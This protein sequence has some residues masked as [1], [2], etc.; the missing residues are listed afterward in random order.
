NFD[1]SEAKEVSL[2]Y[3]SKGQEVAISLENSKAFFQPYYK[4]NL[5]DTDGEWLE[6]KLPVN[7]F[8]EYNL[9]Q[10]TS[11]AISEQFLGSV[12]R[13]GFIAAEKKEGEF[14]FEVDYIIFH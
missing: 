12:Q 1:L 6:V 14:E 11:T 8:K 9:G 4:L 7:G 13:V 3:R 2:R 5:E 10:V